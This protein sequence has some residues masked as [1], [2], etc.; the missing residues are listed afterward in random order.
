MRNDSLGSAPVPTFRARSAAE[1]SWDAL[2]E[3]YNHT[4]LDYI[5]P[6]P[7]NGRRMADYV[8]AYQVDLT[9][10]LVVHDDDENPLGIGMLGLRDRRCWITRLGVSPQG[11]GRGLGTFLMHALLDQGR[12]RGAALAQLEVIQG[13]LPALQLFQKLD[14]KPSRELLV[15]RRP[16]GQPETPDAMCVPL[17]PDAIER[18][19]IE[20]DAIAPSWLDE[21]CSL[22]RL[23]SLMGFAL[24]DAPNNWLVCH[25]G[26]FQLTHVCIGAE[27]PEHAIRLLSH[28]H[29]RFPRFDTKL[30]NLPTYSPLLPAFWA[31]GYYSEFSRLEMLL[32]LP[33][34]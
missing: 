20:R 30:E 23:G 7:M 17:E 21:S 6:M 11:R 18:C 34:S 2:A 26:A 22:L 4:R 29:T 25:T 24:H 13:N 33:I 15:L 10:S 8:Q 14:F 9:A 16:P 1:Y 12:M 31:L 32:P 27:S 5:V 19:L 3:I 28:L